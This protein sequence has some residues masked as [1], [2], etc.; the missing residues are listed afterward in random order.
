M[1]KTNVWTIGGLVLAVASLWLFRTETL[2]AP[3]ENSLQLS[4]CYRSCMARKTLV[5]TEDLGHGLSASI[6]CK[7]N[8]V[9]C[10]KHCRE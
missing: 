8:G 5:C 3:A 10:K 7:V 4:R 2:A 9:N 1:I 6:P